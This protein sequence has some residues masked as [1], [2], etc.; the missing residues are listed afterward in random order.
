MTPVA[1]PNPGATSVGEAN[2]L[3]AQRL[4]GLLEKFLHRAPVRPVRP[5]VTNQAGT[6][7]FDQRPVGLPVRSRFLRGMEKM[8]AVTAV[9]EIRESDPYPALSRL[10]W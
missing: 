10:G 8:K 2:L 6:L 5:G 4:A 7:F 1:D 9:A 3:L